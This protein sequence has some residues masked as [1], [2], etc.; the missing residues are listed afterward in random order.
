MSC[1]SRTETIEAEFYLG[2]DSVKPTAKLIYL[3]VIKTIN[4]TIYVAGSGRRRANTDDT[5]TTANQ[6]SY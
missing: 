6:S 2:T 4:Y 5:A 1:C 3:N